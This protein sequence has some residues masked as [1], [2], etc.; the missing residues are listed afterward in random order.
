ML[1]KASCRRFKEIVAVGIAFEMPIAEMVRCCSSAANFNGGLNSQ[2]SYCYDSFKY[3]KL[4]GYTW[5]SG[6]HTT[7]A[8]RCTWRCLVYRLKPLSRPISWPKW[9]LASKEKSWASA[10]DL[11]AEMHRTK[12]RL[13][14]ELPKLQTL[15]VKMVGF[16][17]LNQFYHPASTGGSLPSTAVKEE[18]T[19]KAPAARSFFSPELLPPAAI[20]GLELEFVVVKNVVEDVE[21]KMMPNFGD[22]RRSPA[23][24][25]M[26]FVEK[27]VRSLME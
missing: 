15:A 7:K 14:K 20:A 3:P 23:V 8:G 6:L 18:S 10:V 12:A 11:N 24:V 2:H 19:P 21:R 1:A 13:L 9:A 16:H 25:K 5:R 17:S 22:H 27:N 26:F 4:K